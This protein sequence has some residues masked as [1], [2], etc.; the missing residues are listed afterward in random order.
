MP[1]PKSPLASGAWFEG[2]DRFPRI[3]ITSEA[4]R[5]RPHD[6][7]R[8]A[9]VEK[10]LP[11]LASQPFLRWTGGKQWLARAMPDL[12]PASYGRYFEPFLGG[13]STYFALQPRIAYLSDAN[14]ELIRTYVALTA[15]P[16]RVID[17]LRRLRYDRVIFE[18]VRVRE[19]RTEAGHAARFIYLNRTAFNGIYRVNQEGR[20]NVPFGRFINPQIC[21]RERLE[22]CAHILRSA[23]M[24]EAHDFEEAVC[25]A[26]AGDFVYFDP[27]YIT[28]HLNNGFV[29]WNAKLFSWQDQ[30][31]LA[32]LASELAKRGVHIL[33]SNADHPAVTQ[34]YAG[35]NRYRVER[36]SQIAAATKKRRK[37]SEMLAS[38]Y[39]LLGSVSDN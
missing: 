13:G 18:R 26:V 10:S 31:R 29:K 30:V 33:V 24:I 35:F 19:A 23:T 12:A 11:P 21:N 37:V 27:P 20:F 14:V 9:V 4:A 1:P 25:S 36:G 22:D 38:S 2:G 8:R 32:N 39:P 16:E 17:N 28:G 15:Q 34:L 6:R 3:E 5:L 7:R